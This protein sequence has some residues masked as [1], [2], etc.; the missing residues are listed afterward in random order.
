L[1]LVE[2]SESTL[3]FDREVKVPLY[4]RHGIRELWIVNLVANRLLV[5][6]E[7]SAGVYTVATTE[8]LAARPLAAFPDVL[9]D[10]APLA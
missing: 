4:A 1:L 10:L 9:I 2:I 3:R 8:A 5:F 6:R 7:P